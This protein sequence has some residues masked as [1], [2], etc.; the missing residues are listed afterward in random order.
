MF[1]F[2]KKLGETDKA[3]ENAVKATKALVHQLVRP[4]L[5]QIGME[6]LIQGLLGSRSIRKFVLTWTQFNGTTRDNND[7]RGRWKSSR[8]VSDGHNDVQLDYIDAKVAAR[9]FA[10]EACVATSLLNHLV[11][12]NRLSHT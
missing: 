4:L 8:Q 7:H 11:Q 9:F 3:V 12:M 1:A 5:V 2:T 6:S 10:R